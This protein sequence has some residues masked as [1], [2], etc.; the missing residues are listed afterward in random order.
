MAQRPANVALYATSNR[1]QLVRR[2]FSDRD[3]E[4]NESETVQEKI[5]LADR[6]GIRIAFS[7]LT[8]QEYLDMVCRLAAREQL[9]WKTASCASGLCFGR[10][11]TP[12]GRRASPCSLSLISRGRTSNRAFFSAVHKKIRRPGRRIFDVVG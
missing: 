2:Y 4:M 10:W 7:S 3:D 1:R 11:S 6:F 9:A 8:R 5:S 12:G